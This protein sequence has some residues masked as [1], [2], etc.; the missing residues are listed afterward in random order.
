MFTAQELFDLSQTEH[1]ALFEG[2]APAWQVLPLLKDYLESILEPACNA[3]VSPLAVIG[4]CVF[5]GKGTVVES[6]ACIE[7]PAI[8][9]SNCQIRH[10]AYVRANVII[11]DGCVV[12]NSSEL[13]N[14]LLFNDCQVPHFNYV[15]D[16][17]VGSH[18]NLGAG[19]ILSNLRNDGRETKVKIG[20]K[21]IN[22]ELRKFGAL[23]GE[24]SQIGCNSVTNPGTIIAPDCM[25][26]P[27]TTLSG[28]HATEGSSIKN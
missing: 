3:S 13:K 7:G 24:R 18:A 23:V 5:L 1:V 28:I 8:I 2:D 26:W 27:N 16:S 25:V 4:D 9:G 10:G 22:T 11:G 20:N 14:S 6:G 12:G 19:V 21:I 17:I 15:G